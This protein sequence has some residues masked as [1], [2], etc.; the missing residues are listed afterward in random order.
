MNISLYVYLGNHQAIGWK[1]QNVKKTERIKPKRKSR[2]TEHELI[3]WN[4]P[5]MTIPVA[6]NRRFV[7]FAIHFA[8]NKSRARNT[9]FDS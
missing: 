5:N 8:Y 3:I 7:S 6:S 1:I 2:K 4:L 9:V